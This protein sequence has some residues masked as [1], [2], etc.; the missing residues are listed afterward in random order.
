M[1]I[2]MGL[3]LLFGGCGVFIVGMRLMSEGLEKSAGKSLRKLFNK[4][5]NNRF[6]GYGIGTV[7]TA[8]IQSSSATTVMTVGLVNAG[9]MTL[10]Q[11]ISIILGANVGTTI[12]GVLVAFSVTSFGGFKI[13]TVFAALALVGAL[14]T[15]ISHNEKVIK[16]GTAL[17][18]FGL[19]FVGLGVM[20]SSFSSSSEAGSAVREAFQKIFAHDA[21]NNLVLLIAIGAL[22]TALIQSSS[23]A[24]GIF[25]SL[26]TSGVIN[27]DQAIL[28]TIGAN[29]G[30]CVTALL[31][32]IGTSQNAKRAAIVHILVNTT[33][34][35]VFG[36]LIACFRNPFR[37]WINAMFAG[38]TQWGLALFNVAFNLCTLFLLP[39]I[40]PIEKLARLIVPDKKIKDEDRAVKYIDELILTTPPIAIAQVHK[41]VLNMAQLAQKNLAVGVDSLLTGEIKDKHVFYKNEEKIN[42]LNKEIASFLIKLS[43]TSISYS[44]EKQL[45]SLH[46]VI[47]DIERIG[48]HATNFIELSEQMSAA[49]LSFS[50]DAVSEARLLYGKVSEMLEESMFILEYRDSS[51]LK[52]M[53]ALEDE[54]DALQKSMSD[55]HIERLTRGD[56]SVESG[57][58]FYALI[59]EL[60]RIADHITNIAFSIKSP[61]GQQSEA[62]AKIEA[63]EKRHASA[64]N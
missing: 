8:T 61:T 11:A 20:S 64:K 42:T 52:E 22:L 50:E 36:I 29:I 55:K 13:D 51:K 41:E 33:F 46:H 30:T 43:A 9:I 34:A 59:T 26:V 44:D 39:F 10:F 48:D 18:G 58:F 38:N 21:M 60:E 32:S 37:E 31:A 4:I 53:A 7:V 15:M 49:G 1:N 47:N 6:A 35:L 57:T 56:C 17:T 24:S 27:L 14:M 62:L 28:L 63:E 16:I 40:R 23:A 3:L 25:I 54:V 19:L 45:G 2:A 5:S 12:T